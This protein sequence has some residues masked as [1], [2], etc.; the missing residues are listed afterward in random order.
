M[1]K[2]LE[3]IAIIGIGAIMPGALN[4]DEFWQNIIQGKNSIIEVP[5]DRWDPDLFY[6]A[7]RTQPDKTYSKIGGFI[8]G[9]KFNS[10]KYKIPPAVAKQMDMVQCLALDITQMALEDSGYDKKEFD[11]TKTAV[12]VANSVGGT[13]NDYSNIRIYRALYY[14]MLKKSAAFKTLPEETKKEIL[15]EVETFVDEKF[16][17][18]NEDT[19]PGELPN[20]IAGRVA[21]IFNLNGTSFAIDAACAS[22]LAAVDQAVNG[23][24]A[25]EYDMAFCGGID[26]MMA[27][28]AYVRFCKIGALSDSG[29]YAFDARANGF[30]MAEGAGMVILKRLSD[31]VKDGDKIYGVI[32][33]VGS[34]S[35]GK[36]KGITAPNPKGQV[37][38][39]NRAFEQVD[40]DPSQVGLMEAHGTATKVGDATELSAL[41]EVF[42]PYAKPGSI[43]L[44]SIKSQIGHTK[45]AAGIASLIKVML[46]LKNKTLPPSINFEKPNPIVDWEKSPFKVITQT[47]PWQ[48][49]KVRTAS[50]SA[51]GFGGTNFH[52]I[53][54]EYDPFKNDFKKEE[55]KTICSKQEKEMTNIKTNYELMV[56]IEKLQG[57]MLIFSGDTKQDLFNK[58]NEVVR[59]IKQENYFLTLLGYKTHTEKHKKF[60]VSINAETPD[61]LKEKIAFF[62]KTATGSDVWS[63]PSLY[64][65]MKGIYPFT[66]TTGKPKVCF[67]F[68]GQGAQYVDM[69]KDLASK[70]KVVRETF[71][72]ADKILKEIIG[73]TLTD[74]LWSKEGESKEDYK[75][76]EEAIK[77][78]QITQPAILTCNVAMMRLL[79]EFG[80]KPDVTMGHSLGEY[81]AAVASGILNFEDAIKAVTIRGSVMSNI[82]LKDTGKMAAVSAS[83]EKIEP[84]LAKISGYVAVANK[85]CP[86]Q[87]VI[88]GESKSVEDAVA[89]FN[90]LGIQA[91]EIPVSHAFHSKMV[92]PAMPSYRKFLDTLDIKAPNLP[93]TS[94]V[95]ADFYP[96]DIEK[97]KDIMTTQI[98]SS[99]EWVKQVELAYKRGVRLFIECGPKRVLSAFVTNTLADKKDIRVL[100]SNHPK[101]GGITEFN[102]LMA[103]LAAAGIGV[104]WSKTDITKEDT[105]FTPCFKEALNLPKPKEE[106]V[107]DL[108]TLK[109]Q[110]GVIK[111]AEEVSLKDD[112]IVISGIGA[113]VFGANLDEILEGKSL[114]KELSLSEQEKQLE[115]NIITSK[116]E[117][118]TSV[119]QV[120]KQAAPKGS[121]SLEREFGLSSE[122][123]K[124]LNDTA[125]LAFASGLL[126]L[127]DAGIA[128]N[129]FAL[130]ENMAQDTGVIFASSLPVAGTWVYEVSTKVADILKGKTKKEV[131]AFYDS[132]IDK[133]YDENLRTQI[134]SCYEE[135]FAK[136]E[137]HTPRS[138]TQDFLTKALP[139]AHT[140]FARLI[141]VSGP[142]L[143]ISGSGIAIEQ[144]LSVAQDWLK[145]AKAN[146]V[147]IIAADEPSGEYLQE[148]LNSAF[149]ARDNNKIVL[150]TAAS[151]I[152]LE[153]GQD[154]LARGLKPLTKMVASGFAVVKNN[155]SETLVN[156]LNDIFAKEGLNKEDFAKELLV[157]PSHAVEEET[158]AL[159][160]FF[161]QNANLIIK[162]TQ[163]QTG[164]TLSS[165]LEEVL[166][167]RSLNTGKTKYA[168]R[169]INAFDMLALTLQEK[170]WSDDTPR[171]V[172][173]TKYQNSLKENSVVKEVKQ[174]IKP[175]VKAEEKSEP[176]KT[177]PAK[178]EPAPK[179]EISEEEL[180]KEIVNLVSEKTGYPQDMLELDLDMEADLGI[181]TVKQAELFALFGEK[182]NL[183]LDQGLQL[184]DYPTI[185]HCIKYVLKEMGNTPVKEVKEEPKAEVKQEEKP[186]IKEEVKTEQA[187]EKK[188]DLKE[189][190]TEENNIQDQKLRFVPITAQA[191][192]T[193]L[194]PRKLSAQRVVLIMCDNGSITKAYVDAFKEQGIKTH[195][196]TTL[197]ARTKN[198]T[199]VNWDSLEETIAAFKDFANNNPLAVQGIIYAL[200]CSIKKFDKKIN[201]NNELTKNLMPLFNACK[202]FIKDL[203]K[204]DDADTF[205]AVVFKIDGNLG[206]K[207]KEA[208]NP[209]I[210]AV[211]GGASCFRKDLH[212]IAGVLT[213]IIDFREDI[214]PEQMAQQTLSEVLTGD[215]RGLICF[216]GLERKTILCLPRKVKKDIKRTD[217]AGKTI[218]FTGAARGIGAILAQKIAKEYQSHILILD[219]I[220]LQ[221]K[222]S[223][224][225]TLSEAELAQLKQELWQK[226]KADT[227]IK[228][229]PVLLEKEFAKIT[230]AVTLYKNIQKLKALGSE[231]D[232]Y[233]CDVTNSS[234]LKDVVMKIKK[235]YGRLDGLIHFAGLEHSKLLTDKTIE[236][237]YKVFAVKATSA[238]A[239]LALNLIKETGF[240]AF[241][242]SIAGKFGNLGQSD[243]ASA[244]DYLAKLA[245]SLHNQGQRAV[246]IAMSAYSKVGMGVRPG[247]FDFLTKQGLKFVD[248]E[249]GMQIF[250][251]EIVYGKVPDIVLTDDLGLLD[252]D[253]QICFDEPNLEEDSLEEDKTQDIPEDN[254]GNEDSGN[255][256]SGNNDYLPK[257]EEPVPAKE[258]EQGDLFSS[259]KEE[260]PVKEE[261]VQEDISFEPEL[262]DKPL[263]EEVKEEEKTKV[264]EEI[265]EE[266]KAEENFFIGNIVSLIKNQELFAKKNY[267]KDEYCLKDHAIEGRPY[268]PGVFGIETFLEAA[269]ILGQN[270]KGLQKVNF[271][272]AIK[273]YRDQEV[274]IKVNNEQ[275]VTTFSLESDFINDKGVKIGNTRKHFSAKDFTTFESAWPEIKNT[276]DFASLSAHNYTYKCAKE[277][278]YRGLFHGPSFQV[279]DGIIKADG[280]S[281]L[282]VYKKP[283]EPLFDDGKKNFIFNPL[284]VEA[285][286]QSCGYRDLV[287]ENRITLPAYIGTIALNVNETPKD[288]LFVL[289]N[290]KDKD[291]E[292]KSVYNAFVFDETGKLWAELADYKMIGR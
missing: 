198:T 174:E 33:A 233:Q 197:R 261:P 281:V 19:M 66:P 142:A 61:K 201:P 26:Q 173:G 270:P 206:Y 185:R 222:T 165:G 167:V 27:P 210:G 103:N 223:Y 191:P 132:F 277:D 188:Q 118:I 248:P 154:V 16:L 151:S 87:T 187:Q 6:S 192:L 49:D 64:L 162:D 60:A 247:V 115:K 172:D 200:P 43:G 52:L 204:R 59:S 39:I 91:V 156:L 256:G 271:T 99:V 180:T 120:I 144:A 22:S 282:S 119:D 109:Q 186:V 25:G 8:T 228:A 130:P 211:Y 100:A 238:A 30:V 216:D 239:F 213:K 246:S 193:P 63:E 45:A 212:E 90:S 48:T 58:L 230:D 179:A 124:T 37:L 83:V 249:V 92:A 276:I 78:T 148:W 245:V 138:F 122:I 291:V 287:V 155:L 121:F 283:E 178:V 170:V 112:Q 3:P 234:M 160:A 190:K 280:K 244:S 9:Y 150:G 292:G 23:L 50:V 214:A 127:K 85:N 82:E 71:T 168:L 171:I 128:L 69:M 164:C 102:D 46:A 21:N 147:I 259:V 29:S 15:K 289:A 73:S 141:G 76:R 258:Q 284:I 113:K 2:N 14:D 44:G 110:F 153:R 56:P 54:Q 17:P 89:L 232:Y 86:T 231:V 136:Y 51:F 32:R 139:L 134:Q 266:T 31:A 205:V 221:E 227:A 241:A 263:N 226:M 257:E 140:Q 126:A 40:F 157:F 196:F 161:G 199:I 183:P 47:N 288:T 184:K 38:A 163:K 88:A 143:N 250:L 145:L 152:I 67:M 70:Y 217:L 72:Q 11:R 175:E 10:L 279:L 106:K 149:V 131:R 274:M 1:K 137:M 13:K 286:F 5:K 57:E 108:N 96:N 166:A 243:Y 219:I 202:I 12:I 218:A 275:G 114:V 135:N 34:S 252:T 189:N 285:A 262:F 41:N 42:S 255:N 272:S 195:V 7:D 94:N 220:E 129:N 169:I 225:A 111:P 105:L 133:I 18:I 80:L 269:K 65:K 240:Y 4:K 84:E 98:M 267:R 81:G 182:Y 62:I 237:Y 253:K 273:F 177:E 159:K 254:N 97:I 93:I 229:T 123:A 35:D 265:K 24:R 260:E 235:K 236:E 36:G 125:K 251:D 176:A 264:K 104:D 117:K 74:V 53:A 116:Q 181:D 20:V 194:E 95:S 158:S 207:T 290:Y 28:G 77:Q 79:Y 75:K 146:R 208:I 242:S 268:F 203:S 68:P 107:F 278:L 101:R 55:V 209:I 215:E 224:Y